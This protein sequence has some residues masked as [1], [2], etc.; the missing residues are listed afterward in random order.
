MVAELEGSRRRK[1]SDQEAPAWVPGSSRIE[2]RDQ[3]VFDLRH[4]SGR[5]AELRG[6]GH[7]RVET[8]I[9]CLEAAEI[10][11]TIMD[12]DHWRF[13]ADGYPRLEYPARGAHGP[14]ARTNPPVLFTHAPCHRSRTGRQQGGASPSKRNVP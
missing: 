5:V 2:V 9:G 1:T 4:E 8:L 13:E 10:T 6:T 7:V 3:L 11:G 12:R 14:G